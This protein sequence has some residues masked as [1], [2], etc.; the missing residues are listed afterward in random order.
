TALLGGDD[1]DGADTDIILDTEF[2]ILGIDADQLD[3]VLPLDV[4]ESLVGDMAIDAGAM[5]DALVAGDI[6]DA[7]DL[8]IEADILDPLLGEDGFSLSDNLG[9]DSLDWPEASILDG[10]ADL[11]GGLLGGGGELLDLPAP[12]G[13]LADG[14]GSVLDDTPLG[15]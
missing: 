10:A 6:G 14:L 11:A 12:D 8:D 3:V 7:L 5:I 9:G 1:N 4:V 2:S 15:V 13:V